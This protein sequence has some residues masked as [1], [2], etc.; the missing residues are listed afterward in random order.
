MSTT[1]PSPDPRV[2]LKGGWFN[3]AEAAW[4]VR[5]VSNTPPS[6]DFMNPSTPGDGRLV[7]SDLAFFGN[8]VI[9]GNYSGFQ[10]WDISNPR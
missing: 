10:I 5:L 8:F 7:N 6:K 3:A 2:G 1:A 4:N 9:Q